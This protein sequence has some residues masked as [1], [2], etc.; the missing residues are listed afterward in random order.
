MRRHGGGL[1]VILVLGLFLAACGRP[2]S[3]PGVQ[4]IDERP[5]AS[6]FFANLYLPAPAPTQRP[7]VV[8]LGGSEGGIRYSA[9]TARELANHGYPSIAVSYF[10]SPGQPTKLDSIPLEQFAAVVGEL[11]RQPG[12]DPRRLVL[13]GNSRGSEAALL[14]ASDHPDLVD[15]VIAQVPSS[16][17]NS[18]VP[19]PTRP[20]WTRD[21]RPVP[22]K[23]VGAADP[24][25]ANTPDAIIPVERVRGPILTVCGGRDAVWPSCPYSAAIAR[26]ADTRP[27]VPPTTVLSYPAAGHT[28][29]VL[30]P[31]LTGPIP[32]DDVPAR[33]GGTAGANARTVTDVQPRVLDFL[34]RL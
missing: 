18:A 2:A 16:V 20:A 23:P 30:G 4:E 26:R 6:A 3:P 1:T 24:A 9:A 10:G 31:A 11:A 29:S 21:G 7:G 22:Y 28:L 8:V 13:W 17:V 33:G 19:D 5:P 14:T 15:A 32:G 34:A 25:P 27:G 12:V